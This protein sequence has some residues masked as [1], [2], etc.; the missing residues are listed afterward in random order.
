M[1]PPSQRGLVVPLAVRR[2]L[3]NRVRAEPDRGVERSHAPM[4]LE[5]R[6]HVLGDEVR[7]VL[8]HPI[9]RRVERVREREQVVRDAVRAVEALPFWTGDDLLCKGY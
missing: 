1:A 6:T 4:P 7:I 3:P 5:H 8:H 9:N 2:L